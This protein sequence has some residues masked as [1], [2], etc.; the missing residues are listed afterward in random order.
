M[1]RPAAPCSQRDGPPGM[2]AGNANREGP[3][4]GLP[5]VLMSSPRAPW[6]PSASHRWNPDFPNP[7][8]L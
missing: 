3:T 5:S 4:G 6:Y 8:P 1:A 2:S 7:P